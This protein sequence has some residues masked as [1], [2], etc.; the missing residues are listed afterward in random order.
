MTQT[1]FAP[2][3]KVRIEENVM[4]AASMPLSQLAAA[5]PSPLQ[6]QTRLVLSQRSA[7]QRHTDSPQQID[8]ARAK[9]RA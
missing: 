2:G 4:Q 9:G 6:H 3:D 8:T 7:Y 5:A 1:C